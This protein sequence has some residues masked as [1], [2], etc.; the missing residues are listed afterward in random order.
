MIERQLSHMIYVRM[1]IKIAIGTIFGVI[2]T[3]YLEIYV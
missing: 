2:C 3:N 1:Q